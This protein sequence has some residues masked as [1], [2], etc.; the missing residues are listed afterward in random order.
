LP[1]SDNR[2]LKKHIS[3]VRKK[4]EDETSSCIIKNVRGEGYCFIQNES[5]YH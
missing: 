2:S 1:M 5:I 4:L 3:E